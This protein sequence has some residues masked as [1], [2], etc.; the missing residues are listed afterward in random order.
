MGLWSTRNRDKSLIEVKNEIW[1]LLEEIRYEGHMVKKRSKY[2]L[3]ISSW[4]LQ[5]LKK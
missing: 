4:I 3:S 2:T 5:F 1:S